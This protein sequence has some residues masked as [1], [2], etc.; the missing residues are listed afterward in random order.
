MRIAAISDVHGNYEA[1]DKILTDISNR[2]VDKVICCGDVVGYGPDPVQC[3]QTLR[4]N[5]VITIQGNHDLGVTG[6][7]SP[8]GWRGEAVETWEM[9]K[10]LLKESEISW[11]K[12]HPMSIKVTKNIL[13]V[14]GSPRQPVYEYMYDANDGL[15]NIPFMSGRICF[16]GHSHIPGV[17]EFGPNI[18]L[19]VNYFPRPNMKSPER[20]TIEESNKYFINPGSVGQP[21]D[22]NPRSSYCI[23]DTDAHKVV[24]YRIPYNVEATKDRMW[25]YNY[26]SFLIERL[27]R[28]N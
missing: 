5:N 10:A 15:S 26:P 2:N 27:T 18:T 24:F 17:I 7:I 3:I 23:L 28:G 8:Y 19:G 9:A 4:E 12:S 13:M 20:V 11:L 25:R 14:H 21:R 1:L 6:E 16:H 22:G